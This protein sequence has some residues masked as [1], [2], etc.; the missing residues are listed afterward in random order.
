VI[1]YLELDQRASQVAN[2]LIVLGRHPG[3]RIDYLG[4][5]PDLYFELL[6]GALKANVVLV[7][8]RPDNNLELGWPGSPSLCQADGPQAKDGAVSLTA[9]H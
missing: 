9:G 3:T 7:S 6:F 2:G 1:S 5:N 4:K 8:P